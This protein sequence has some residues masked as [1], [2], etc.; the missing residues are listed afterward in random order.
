MV[1]MPNIEFQSVY[2][3]Q[4]LYAC[5]GRYGCGAMIKYEDLERHLQF[6]AQHGDPV[7][8]GSMGGANDPGPMPERS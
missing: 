7:D 6:H 3:F 4:G 5:R 2:Q 1:D 8:L